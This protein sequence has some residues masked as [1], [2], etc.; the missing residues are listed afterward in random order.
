MT[1]APIARDATVA[2]V[3]AG[4]MGCGIAQIAAQA[5]HRVRLF[6]TRLGVAEKARAGIGQTLNALA[7]KGRLDA[8]E[9]G[10]LGSG[11]YATATNRPVPNGRAPR[12]GVSPGGRH[13]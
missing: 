8:G 13:P 10:N 2:V 5:G 9:S 1:G 4:T 11:L 12:T 7:A 3:G 6:D